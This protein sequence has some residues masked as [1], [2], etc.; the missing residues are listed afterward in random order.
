VDSILLLVPAP[1]FDS[2]KFLTLVYLPV[3]SANSCAACTEGLMC[4]NIRGFGH[5][6]VRAIGATN[7]NNDV[8]ASGHAAQASE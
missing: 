5:T 4:R 3:A 6:P 8:P 7:E 1:A 2:L